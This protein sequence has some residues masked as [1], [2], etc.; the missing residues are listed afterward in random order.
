MKRDTEKRKESSLKDLTLPLKKTEK[1]TK[2]VK[3]EKKKRSLRTDDQNLKGIT[4]LAEHDT[5]QCYSS[6]MMSPM[7][8]SSERSYDLQ[9][10]R[11]AKCRS[12]LLC[13]ASPDDNCASSPPVSREHVIASPLIS[14][15]ETYL[16]LLHDI[17][18]PPNAGTLDW[19]KNAANLLE[20]NQSVVESLSSVSSILSPLSRQHALNRLCDI[21]LSLLTTIK[22]TAA[23]LALLNGDQREKGSLEIEV[24]KVVWF[25][26]WYIPNTC[27][28]NEACLTFRMWCLTCDFRLQ[29]DSSKCDYGDLSLS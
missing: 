3:K 10:A 1:A 20:Q 12:S 21:A 8:Q 24:S 4:A 13:S 27:L 7:I 26:W 6:L 14:F 19:A 2:L 5:G 28:Y 29:N 15:L 18:G 16:C 17:K 25:R 11:T 22:N 23:V 9:A